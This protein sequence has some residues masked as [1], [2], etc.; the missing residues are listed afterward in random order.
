MVAAKKQSDAT[1]ADGNTPHALAGLRAIRDRLEREVP[2]FAEASAVEREAE[3]FCRQIR[4]ELRDNRKNLQVGQASLGETMELTQSAVSK[5][6]TADGDIGLK[7]VY[8][9]LAA[10]GLRPVMLVVPSAEAI[11]DDGEQRSQL[12]ESGVFDQSIEV[13]QADL[14]RRISSDLSEFMTAMVKDKA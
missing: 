8:R 9:Y 2:G 11:L 4:Q 3:A 13:A 6:E 14:L 7:T 1:D 12:L 10:L 5:I